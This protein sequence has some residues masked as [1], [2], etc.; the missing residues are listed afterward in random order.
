ML[1]DSKSGCR[2]ST[3]YAFCVMGI[4][5]M[6]AKHVF[7]LAGKRPRPLGGELPGRELGTG[8]RGLFALVFP[9]IPFVLSLHCLWCF[10]TI[11]KSLLIPIKQCNPSVEI[12]RL[13]NLGLVAKMPKPAEQDI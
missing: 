1:S 6:T 11:K 5:Q 3:K 8:I 10:C 4:D 13:L 9:C 2:A 7:G 12:W